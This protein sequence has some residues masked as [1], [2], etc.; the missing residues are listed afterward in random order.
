AGRGLEPDEHELLAR[1]ACDELAGPRDAD[2][3]LDARDAPHGRAARGG[4]RLATFLTLEHGEPVDADAAAALTTREPQLPAGTH[5]PPD[6]AVGVTG[7]QALAA[8]PAVGHEA[9]RLADACDEHPAVGGAHVRGEPRA[10][11]SLPHREEVLADGLHR[12]SHR[13]AR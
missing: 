8:R 11:A 12:E 10:S 6:G 7:Q 4:D 9:A 13:L 5:A 3:V 2:D 1:E